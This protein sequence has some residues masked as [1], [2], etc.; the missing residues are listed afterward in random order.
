MSYAEILVQAGAEP[1]DAGRLA[2]ASELAQRFKAALTG[3]YL[4]PE[5]ALRSY[6]IGAGSFGPVAQTALLEALHEQ[7]AAAESESGRARQALETASAARGVTPGFLMLAADA[8]VTMTTLA[9][10]ADLTIMPALFNPGGAGLPAADVAMGCGGP[11]LITPRAWPYQPVGRR[12]M[13]AWNGSRESSR[14]LRDALPV[15]K[16]A[17]SI[18]VVMVDHDPATE[19]AEETVPAY[20]ARHGCKATPLR[21]P[22]GRAV[23]ERDPAGHG[24][25]TGLRPDRHGPLRSR[26]G[27]GSGAGRRQPGH[28]APR[29]HPAAGVALG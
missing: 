18:E 27:P 8:D 6:L 5:P 4:A 10:R 7:E 23:G 29:Q 20:L 3:V 28:P 2:L 19:G 21:T 12:V 17:E 15:L 9:K 13:L 16:G 22:F 11:V 26:P 25:A 24:G 14:A 1:T